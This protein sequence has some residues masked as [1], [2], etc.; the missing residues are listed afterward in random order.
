MCFLEKF[1]KDLS[2]RAEQITIDEFI[3][4]CK[5]YGDKIAYHVL[6]PLMP[7]GRS[8]KGIEDGVFEYLENKIEKM[9]LE[10][11]SNYLKNTAPEISDTS[12]RFK[13]L[14][15][16]LTSFVLYVIENMKD[17]FKNSDFSP[18]LYD[19]NPTF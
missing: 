2:Y 13:Y 5:E 15:K 3:E 14:T 12:K 10:S 7:S 17:E 8:S 1:G 19:T 6:L 18:I 9:A 11:A 4:I 16:R